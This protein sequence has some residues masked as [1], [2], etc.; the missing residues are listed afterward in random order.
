LTRSVKKIAQLGGGTANFIVCRNR[1]DVDR[2]HA[3]A[4]EVSQLTYQSRLLRSGLPLTEDFRLSLKQLADEHR[5]YAYLLFLDGKPIS[6]AYCVRHQEIISYNN[7]GYDPKYANM[8][9]GNVLLFYILESIFAESGIRYFDF[10][11]GN[12]QYKALFS[13]N[14]ELVADAFYFRPNIR[15]LLTMVAHYGLDRLSGTSGF[16]LSRFGLK[17]SMR[18]MIRGFRS[19]KG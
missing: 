3:A 4:A 14:H 9:P 19:G 1:E 11:P 5:L 2:F 17:E 18:K 13:T 8:S 16:L 6:F 7:I 15:N 10:G 12:A